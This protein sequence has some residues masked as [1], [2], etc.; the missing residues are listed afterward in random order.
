VNKPNKKGENKIQQQKQPEQNKN[1]PRL[2]SQSWEKSF[3]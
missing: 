3:A 2:T 1:P